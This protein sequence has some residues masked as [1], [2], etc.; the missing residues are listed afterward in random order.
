MHTHDRPRKCPACGPS[1]A[2]SL[3]ACFSC[4]LGL[5][6]AAAAS[7]L[8]H[9]SAAAASHLK[10]LSAAADE[11]LHARAEKYRE[12]RV[13]LQLEASMHRAE[14]LAVPVVLQRQ[15]CQRVK[16]KRVAHP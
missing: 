12:Q 11:R 13:G 10:H 4:W 3:R 8:K 7:H 15:I 5:Y 16:R 9:L 6:C 2:A 14:K 1:A